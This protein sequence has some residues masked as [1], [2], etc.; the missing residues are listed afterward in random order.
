MGST[1]AQKILGDRLGREVIP[2][3]IVTVPVTY[4]MSNDVTA[5]L[6]IEHFEKIGLEKVHDPQKIIFVLDHFVPCKDINSAALCKKTRTFAAE[7]GVEH[8]Y[9]MGVGGIEHALL[10]ERGL[11]LPGDVVI[12]GDSHTCTYGALGAFATG[13]GSTDI[14]AAMATGKI[15]LRVPESMKFLYS[16]SLNKWVSAKDLILYTLGDIGVS[17]A[18]Y[19]VMEFTGD[20]IEDMSMDG[21][22]TICNMAV[23]AGAKTGIIE[24]DF[25]TISY[26]ERVASRPYRVYKSDPNADYI[27]V[28]EYEGDNIEVQVALPPSPSNVRPVNEVSGIPVDQAVIGSCTNGRIEDLR[29][30]AKILRGKKIDR[31]VRL[32]IFPATQQIYLQALREGLVEI[33]IKAGG[34]VNAPSCGPC[35]GGHLGVLA[36]GERAVSTTNRNFIGRMGHPKSEIY[37]SSPAVA[38]ASAIRGELTHPSEAEAS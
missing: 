18:L 19:K 5:P 2:G 29:T 31:D 38:A 7:Q 17:G 6:A 1:I 14:A 15:W 24:P 35:L 33:F 22:F 8:L 21:R 32:L 13:V 11:V 34:V 36:E 4:A 37:L 16:G 9:D 28:K 23:E 10:P 25:K 20:I 3:E 27:E 12:G 26:V 30:A